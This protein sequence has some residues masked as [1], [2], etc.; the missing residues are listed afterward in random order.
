MGEDDQMHGEE[1]HSKEVGR[2]EQVR[3][4]IYLGLTCR[5]GR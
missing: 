5:M 3:F 2:E 1:E 4:L